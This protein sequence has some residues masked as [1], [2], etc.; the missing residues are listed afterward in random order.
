M[1]ALT[2]LAVFW[3]V[4]TGCYRAEINTGATPSGKVITRPIAS[5]FLWGLVG[6]KPIDAR[7]ECGASRVAKVETQHS[8]V[9]SVIAAVTLGIYTPIRITVTCSTRS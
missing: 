7:Q 2:V 5:G 8:F 1:R 9:N 6:P 4:L 3:F